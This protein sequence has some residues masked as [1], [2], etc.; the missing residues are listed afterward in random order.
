MIHTKIQQ[1]VPKD[2]RII[3]SG[4]H[5]AWFFTIFGLAFPAIFEQFSIFFTGLP[6][7]P[8]VLEAA[9]GP[10]GILEG[11]KENGIWIDHSTTDY[12]QNIMFEEIASK[13]GAHVLECPITG[14]LEALKKGQM[15]VWVAGNED[16]YK[17]AR[18]VL[19]ASYTTVLYTGGHS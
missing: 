19:D 16:A 6:K 7:P 17:R 12:E 4:L 5:N 2:F 11:L 8:N 1:L 3:F 13:K 15:A 18:P 9:M 10:N 14:G